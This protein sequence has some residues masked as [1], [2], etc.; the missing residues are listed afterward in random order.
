MMSVNTP[1]MKRADSMVAIPADRKLPWKPKESWAV[2]VHSFLL[3]QFPRHF[4]SVSC[5]SAG[6][7]VRADMRYE[8]VD[9]EYCRRA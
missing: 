8:R 2:K 7:R 9:R 1:L 5:A 3:A 6:H 4:A